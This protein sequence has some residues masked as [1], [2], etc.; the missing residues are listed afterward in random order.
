MSRLQTD[1]GQ[2]LAELAA[3]LAEGQRLSRGRR[4]Q[5]QGHVVDLD[6]SPG[7][8]TASVV[9]SRSDPYEVS[10]ACKP[11]NE[12]ERQ[13]AAHDVTGAIPRLIDVAFTCICPDWGDPCKH[14]IAVLLE[15]AREV[16][17]D[18]ALLLGWRGID[19]V[20]A[21]PPPGTESLGIHAGPSPA[22]DPAAVGSRVAGSLVAASDL[23]PAEEPEDSALAAFFHGAVPDEP[24]GLVSPLDEVQLDAFRRVRIPL[25]QVDAAPVFADAI[26]A[27]AEHWLDR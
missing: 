5:R 25:E 20:V 18:P 22:A 17:D 13:A 6:V 19:D 27:I 11:A 23:G 14:G 26:D 1:A 16:D 10:I 24:T 12:N 15:L 8:V 2:E 9:G 21:P 3:R 7:L 4:Y